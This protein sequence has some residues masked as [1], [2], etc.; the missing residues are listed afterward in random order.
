MTSAF[1]IVVARY[2]EDISWLGDLAKDC[3]IVYNKG[4]DDTLRHTECDY[5]KVV[6]LPNVGRESHTYLHHI[7]QNYNTL[8]PVTIF[9][10]A[11]I[12]D[13][14]EGP[15]SPESGREFLLKLGQQASEFGQSQNARLYDHLGGMSAIPSFNLRPYYANGLQKTTHEN[16]GQWFKAVVGQ[17]MPPQGVP[18]YKNAL[19]AVKRARIHQHPRSFYE[20]LL[21]EVDTMVNPETGHYFER[22]W[23]MI[24]ST[25]T[26]PVL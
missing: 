26:N 24:F 13:H 4:G 19:F 16:L 10:Q 8:A 22:S 14:F 23:Y 3:C 25:R 5:K 2:T 21:R 1:E 7:I 11:R 12:E 17:D 9:T 6:T 20:N 18:W 15:W